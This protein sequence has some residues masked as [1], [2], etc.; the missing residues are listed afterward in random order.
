MKLVSVPVCF[1]RVSSTVLRSCDL[2]GEP[3]IILN[4]QYRM[5][6]VSRTRIY[7]LPFTRGAGRRGP[8]CFGGARYSALNDT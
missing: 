5:S 2:L 7:T 1:N 6:V 4:L 8:V 3:T